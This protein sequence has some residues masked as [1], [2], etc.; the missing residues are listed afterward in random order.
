[1]N[2]HELETTEEDRTQVTHANPVELD[3]A[4]PTVV[5]EGTRRDR[6]GEDGTKPLPEGEPWHLRTPTDLGQSILLPEAKPQKLMIIT[7]TDLSHHTAISPWTGHALASDAPASLE[8]GDPVRLQL[9]SDATS[10]QAVVV[11]HTVN[12]RPGP[13]SAEGAPPPPEGPAPPEWLRANVDALHDRLFKGSF[14]EVFRILESIP[15]DPPPPPDVASA[16]PVTEEK[17]FR[18]ALAE[19]GRAGVTDTESPDDLGQA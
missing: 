1:M 17:A 14:A 9:R 18:E 3:R 8:K 5:I 15:L 10:T 6:T 16:P 12:A 11:G 7:R 19:L 4:D 2:G 13:R